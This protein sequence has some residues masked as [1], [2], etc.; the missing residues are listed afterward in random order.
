M[1]GN[2]FRAGENFGVDSEFANIGGDGFR[3]EAIFIAELLRVVHA[4]KNHLVAGG[5]G[6]RQRFLE[7]FAAHGIGTRLK[8][9]PQAASRPTAA[10]SGD[11]GAN[12]SGM[13]R[14]IVDDEH[15]A[16]FTLYVE[17][18]LYAFERF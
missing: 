17:A 11:R 16:E 12:G 15:P 14:K 3:I 9:G 1:F 13:M 18:A 10:R 4:A 2:G 6:L 8:Y 7:N 5:E